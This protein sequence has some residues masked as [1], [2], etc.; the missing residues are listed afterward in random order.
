MTSNIQ[1]DR[2]KRILTVAVAA[3]VLVV[4]CVGV[5][6]LTSKWVMRGSHSWYHHDQPHGH[7]WL[8]ETLGLTDEEAVAIDTFEAAYREEKA[9]LTAEFESRIADLRALLVERDRYSP[10]VNTAIHRIHEVHGALQELSIRH[11]YD[12]LNVL[13]PEKQEK[14]RELAVKALSQPE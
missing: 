12:M 7:Q 8:H 6:V 3:A 1:P 10:E 9:V 14:L 5:S 13:P 4:L 2:T 11:Y